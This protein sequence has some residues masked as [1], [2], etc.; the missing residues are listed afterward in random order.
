MIVWLTD[1]P[2]FQHIVIDD[3]IEVQRS[4]EIN[5]KLVYNF[6]DKYITTEMPYDGF[7]SS[8]EP[9]TD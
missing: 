7:V 1:A 9:D 3:D 5:N 6:I 2:K 4:K 8:N